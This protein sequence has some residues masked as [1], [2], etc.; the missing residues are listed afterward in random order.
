MLQELPPLLWLSYRLY[1]ILLVK[2]DVMLLLV[3]SMLLAKSVLQERGKCAVL[4]AERW[5]A[6]S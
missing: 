3:L 5:G 1:A 6:C 4:C 2:R